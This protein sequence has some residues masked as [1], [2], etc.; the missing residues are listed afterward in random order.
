MQPENRDRLLRRGRSILA[1]GRETVRNWLLQHNGWSWVEPQAGGMAFL[2]YDFAMPSE[3]FSARLR[4]EESVF[5]CAGSWFGLEGHIR[6]GIGVT[7]DHL[8]EGLRRID[9]F[10]ARHQP[11]LRPPAG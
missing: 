1:E 10:L 2:G 7:P 9:R 5:V 8:R 3:D 4:E 11:S 6:I